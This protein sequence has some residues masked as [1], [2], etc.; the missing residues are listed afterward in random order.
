MYGYSPPYVLHPGSDGIKA[1][2]VANWVKTDGGL[3]VLTDGPFPF[4][5]ETEASG[6]ML[7][8]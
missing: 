7:A 5:M 3:V 6:G 4:H 1:R 2:Q 8:L